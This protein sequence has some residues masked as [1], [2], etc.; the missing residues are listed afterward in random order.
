MENTVLEIVLK[1]VDDVNDF[2]HSAILFNN[3]I[4]AYRKGF[5]NC[6]VDAKSPTSIMAISPVSPF[7]IELNSDDSREKDAF[8][9][10]FR[11]YEV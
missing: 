4:D 10:T 8:I 6:T 1:D 9:E 7:L 3:D 5:K 2:L 11:K